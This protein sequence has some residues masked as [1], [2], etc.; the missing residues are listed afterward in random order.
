MRTFFTFL[1]LLLAVTLAQAGSLRLAENGQ[2]SWKIA[3]PAEPTDVEKTAARELAE[4]LNLITG[5]EFPTVS[6]ADLPADAQNVLFV[7]NG[8]AMA[9]EYAKA[10]KTGEKP[11]KFDEIFIRTDGSNLYL[12]GHERRGAL[13]AVY[14]FLQDT[15]GVR[16]WTAECSFIPK[17][18]TLEVAD[19]LSV[20]YAPQL[21]SREMYHRNAQKPIFSARM[22]GNGHI[23]EE[24]GGRVSIIYFV[25][26]FFRVLPPEKYFDAHPEWYS[27]INGERK[28]G[29]TQLCLSNDEMR[30]EYVRVILEELRKA[31]DPR[32][33]DVSQNDWGGWCQCEKCKALAEQEGSQAGPLIT[34]L[35]KVAEDIE[36]EF[37]DVLV[38]TLAYQQSR[39]P[40]KTVRPRDNVLV[41]L[42]SIECSF[43]QPLESEQNEK[44]A[45]DIDGWSKIAKHLFIWD[46]VT[47]YRAY[48]E[49]FPN[50]KVLAPNLRFFLKHGAVGLFCEGEGDDFCELKNWLLMRLM[51]EPD[52]DE[53]ALIKEFCDG[54]Y[55][56]EITPF[57]Q[58][59]WDV[60]SEQAVKSGAFIGCFHNG[61]QDWLDLKTLNRTTKL[62]N[63]AVA[64]SRKIYGED[65]EQFA[66]LKKAKM[67]V[68]LVWINRWFPLMNEARKTGTPVE[69][70]TVLGDACRDFVE[71]C[72]KVKTQALIIS[73]ASPLKDQL[74]GMKNYEVVR[75]NPPKECEDADPATW[76][77]V[78][79]AVFGNYRNV[80]VRV[81]DPESI[82]GTSTRMGTE[83]DWNT[84]CYPKVVGKYHIWASMRV[85]A[86]IDEG[87]AGQIGVYDVNGKKGIITHALNVEDLKGPKYQWVD[88]GV[89]DLVPNAYIWF[90]HRHNPKVEALYVDRLV[91]KEAE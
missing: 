25:H 56:P 86:E 50:L 54:Y 44:F 3:L 87:L 49:P 80:A 70:P 12:G 39:K 13:Y 4:H 26:S 6:E 73:Q 83:V 29:H 10:G 21:I 17:K 45:S 88:L 91:F 40:P 22:K 68:D 9:A 18:P 71:M 72:E 76:F 7:G 2:T 53:N 15:L 75:K 34:F 89:V 52:L 58:E 19:D 47:N 38:E 64:K 28:G 60:L 37:P 41:R 8:S 79:D 32:F 82:D 14:S 67:G 90:A 23:S 65:S 43:S 63:Q 1:T 5:A 27:E 57:I 77:A 81:N 48:V 62:M 20:S 35:N 61:S 30:K 24:Y 11:F 33:I 55:G 36:K 42:C 85:D 74:E 69:G 31:K 46:Y 84:Q 16:W 51:W 78:D 66:H 59:Y